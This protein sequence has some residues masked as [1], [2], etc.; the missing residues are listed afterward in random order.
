M[1]T[2]EIKITKNSEK[3]ARNGKVSVGPSFISELTL[4]TH[5]EAFYVDNLIWYRLVVCT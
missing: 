2:V 4:S 1:C 3:L 5:F